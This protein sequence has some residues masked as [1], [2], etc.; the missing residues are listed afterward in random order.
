M[1]DS[2]IFNLLFA[3]SVDISL[4]TIY[5]GI[6]FVQGMSSKIAQAW[7]R[8]KSDF[9][10]R[11]AILND[12]FFVFPR[13]GRSENATSPFPLTGQSKLVF[14]FNDMLLPTNFRVRQVH[15]IFFYTRFYPSP[16]YARYFPVLCHY[17]SFKLIHNSSSKSNELLLQLYHDKLLIFSGRH[18]QIIL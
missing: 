13:S 6:S 10:I 2:L 7:E 9:H 1:I 18:S 12:I 8:I 5:R 14:R 4:A 3:N 11:T 16:R 15:S 17:V